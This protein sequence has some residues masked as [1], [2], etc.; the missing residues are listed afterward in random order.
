MGRTTLNLAPGPPAIALS[1]SRI[2]KAL[3]WLSSRNASSEPRQAEAEGDEAAEETEEADAAVDEGLAAAATPA[4]A[5]ESACAGPDSTT[6]VDQRQCRRRIIR[7]DHRMF[8]RVRAKVLQKVFSDP[9]DQFCG[10][11]VAVRVEQQGATEEV[12]SGAQVRIGVET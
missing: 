12:G 4:A 6:A 8:P 2:P 9:V 10:A 1:F 5:P 3:L 11:T 7:E